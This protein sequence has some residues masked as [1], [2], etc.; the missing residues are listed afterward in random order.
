MP[1]LTR[2]LAKL[3]ALSWPEQRL[4]LTAM[5]LLPLFW[6]G[7][8]VLGLQRFQATLD[9]SSALA[10]PSPKLVIASEARQS[11]SQTEPMANGLPP[12]EAPPNSPLSLEQMTRLGALV[13]LAARHAPGPA[14][15]LTRSLLLRWLLR[16]RGVESDL[17]IGVKLD[18][19][20]L[21]A[22]AWVEVVGVPINDS[23]DVG[24]RFAAFSQPLS[25]EAFN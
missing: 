19:G 15:C 16:R 24:Q 25:P 10:K 14:T 22:H 17:R 11:S 9:R 6:L 20:R 3:R 1:T 18:Q 23:Q 13:N 5:L 2:K 21:D 12:P 4:L 7:L 8:R